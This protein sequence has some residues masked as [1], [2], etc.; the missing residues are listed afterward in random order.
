MEIA[1]QDFALGNSKTLRMSSLL[2]CMN[3]K[4]PHEEFEF[5]ELDVIGECK[6]PMK[7]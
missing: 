4:S 2:K 7:Y 6:N 1:R 5:M 3:P